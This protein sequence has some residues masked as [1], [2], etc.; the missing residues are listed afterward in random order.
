[1][2]AAP[3][4]IRRIDPHVKIISDEVVAR[5]KARGLDAIVYAPHY[6]RFPEIQRRAKAYSDSELLVIPGRE[7]F[8]GRWNNRK[9]VL[10]IGLEQPVPDFI[11]L[12]G[13]MAELDRQGATVLV[14]HPNFFTVGLTSVDCRRYRRIIDAIEVYNPKH[15]PIHNRRA[16]RLAD[17]LD[18][19][20][21]GSSYAHLPNTVGEVWTEFSRSVHPDE[22]I[23]ALTEE[24][25]HSVYRK[26]GWSHRQRKSL[27]FFHL[28]WEN[29]WK[30][31]DRVLLSEQEST[32]PEHPAYDGRF[33]NVTAYDGPWH[34]N[35]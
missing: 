5:A 13:A 35:S 31:I 15:L 17:L 34:L 24:R 28:G 19:P 7:I 8:T 32:H 11:T 23:Q 1:M 21:F 6:T 25:S 10:A 9:H 30:K 2:A 20:V 18:A 4:A 22:C 14:P 26:S 33:T 16:R 12:D 29:S 3:T 27:E